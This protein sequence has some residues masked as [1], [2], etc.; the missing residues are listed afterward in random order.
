[1]HLAEVFLSFLLPDEI[2]NVDISNNT[3]PILPGPLIPLSP[4]VN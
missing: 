1:M 3:H 4:L 2:D